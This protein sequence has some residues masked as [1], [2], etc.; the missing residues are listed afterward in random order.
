MCFRPLMFEKEGIH[1]E[2]LQNPGVPRCRGVGEVELRCSVYFE[3]SAGLFFHFRYT[4][5]RNGSVKFKEADVEKECRSGV[6]IELEPDFNIVDAES[7]SRSSI[8]S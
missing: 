5:T 6:T 1:R 8:A 2:G 3:Q 4:R 7:P